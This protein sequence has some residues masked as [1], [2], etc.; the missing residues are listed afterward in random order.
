MNFLEM[1]NSAILVEIGERIRRQ[2]LNQNITQIELAEKAGVARSV[3]QKLERGDKCMLSGLI[4]ILRVLGLLDQLDSFLPDPGVSPLQLAR[5]HGQKR[6]RASGNRG[7]N[8]EKET[9]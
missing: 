7:N 3:V 1:S 2:R 8:S 6:Q 4:R 9:D 5:L